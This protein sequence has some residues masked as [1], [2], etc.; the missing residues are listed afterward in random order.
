MKFK[1]I[2]SKRLLKHKFLEID[3]VFLEVDKYN[4]E[5]LHFERLALKRHE[6]SAVLLEISET[7]EIVLVE[8]FRYS[9]ANSGNCWIQEVVAGVIEEGE[10]PET[11]A[12]REI[13]EETGYLADKL[14]KIYVFYPSVGISNQIMHLFFAQIKQNQ[15]IKDHQNFFDE[16]EDI[17]LCYYKKEEIFH[18][19][20]T[21]KIIDAK[22][23]IALQWYLSKL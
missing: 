13:K 12:V 18:L 20:Q 17:K 10:K 3:S 19:L 16:E 9:A 4:G 6:V 1:E 23:I 5:K 14:E 15:R 11:A 2:S 8:Q 7:K 21:A 22:T